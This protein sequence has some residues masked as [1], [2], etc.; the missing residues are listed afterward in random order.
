MSALFGKLVGE[1]GIASSFANSY[2]KLIHRA[3][4]KYQKYLTVCLVPIA[5]AIFVYAGVN[6]L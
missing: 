6:L 5:N 3:P 1:I 4:E 2:E